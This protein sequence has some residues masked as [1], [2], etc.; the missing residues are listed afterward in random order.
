MA[1]GKKK[2]SCKMV[3]YLK[4]GVPQKKENRQKRQKGGDNIS[5][6]LHFSPVF[7]V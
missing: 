1:G 4:K 3:S 6:I 7:S 5:T 2:S